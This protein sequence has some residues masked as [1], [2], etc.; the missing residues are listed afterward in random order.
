MCFMR[1]VHRFYNYKNREVK[2]VVKEIIC[3]AH[4]LVFELP[5][6]RLFECVG[7]S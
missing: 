3:Q 2:T 5:F 4:K 6:D 1:K 7:K